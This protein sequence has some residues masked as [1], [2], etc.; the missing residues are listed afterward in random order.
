MKNVEEEIRDLIQKNGPITFSQ[1]MQICLYSPR[2]GFYSTRANK[3]NAEFGTSPTSHPLFGTL[4]AKQL[5]QM[6]EILEFPSS[7]QVIEVGSGDG[8]LARSIVDEIQLLDSDFSD[9]L[10]YVATDYEP[11]WPDSLNESLGWDGE[12]QNNRSNK[13][14]MTW[15]INR[16]KAEGV[17]P[18]KNIT[19]CIL[20]N[21][22]VDNFPFHQFVI[23]DGLVKE[24]YV[25]TSNKGFTEILDIPSNPLITN[26]LESL[27]LSLPEGYRG[28]INLSIDT[29]MAEVSKTLDKGFILSID[30]G[31]L[32]EDLYSSKYNSRTLMCYNQHQY[33]NNPYQN[34]ICRFHITYGSWRKARFYN[35]GIFITAQIF[36]K[37]WFLFLFRFS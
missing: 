1:F 14:E 6:W 4:I 31:E 22:L 19:G 33:N 9:A 15:G 7:F 36:R 8:A 30:Y 26:R 34:I 10:Q 11:W 5:K 32:S 25:T 29:W 17:T 24:I 35:T 13:R 2:G 18:F 20:C 27:N 28:E 12:A 16:I 23:Q 37:P 21:E 3:I